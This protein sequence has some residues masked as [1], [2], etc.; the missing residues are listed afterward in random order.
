MTQTFMNKQMQTRRKLRKLLNASNQVAHKSDG[1]TII[2]F[3]RNHFSFIISY[4]DND[5]DVKV[6]L[7][8]E[9]EGQIIQ[10]ESLEFKPEEFKIKLNKLVRI[11]SEIDSRKSNKIIKKIQKEFS[12]KKNSYVVVDLNE[13]TYNQM[14]EDAVKYKQLSETDPSIIFRN[15]LLRIHELKKELKK[16][17]SEIQ[18]D[19]LIYDINDIPEINVPTDSEIRAARSKAFE[20]RVMKRLHGGSLSISRNEK[21]EISYIVREYLNY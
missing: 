10:L 21:E 2:F 17:E 19:L 4:K 12:L 6:Y 8:K 1:S 5:G 7:T 18:G 16:L 14:M 13:F 9:K 20:S 3:N 15:K 11:L